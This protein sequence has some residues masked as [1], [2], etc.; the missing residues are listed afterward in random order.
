MRVAAIPSCAQAAQPCGRIRSLVIGLPFIGRW[1]ALLRALV[2][3]HAARPPRP[4]VAPPPPPTVESRAGEV[5]VR[6]VGPV[7]HA[8]RLAVSDDGG[9][10]YGQFV[11]SRTAD[12][13]YRLHRRLP[14]AAILIAEVELENNVVATAVPDLPPR[15][16]AR[17]R[18]FGDHP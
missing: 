1:S 13:T 4:F 15:F 10:T 16:R 5:I 6:P 7:P 17:V 8:V 12:G 3:H 2:A 14:P 9:F 11:L 18:A